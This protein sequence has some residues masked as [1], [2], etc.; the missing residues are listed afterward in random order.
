MKLYMNTMILDTDLNSDCF[1]NHGLHMNSSGKDQ[2]IMKLASVIESI[3]VNNSE[4]NIELQ[5]KDNGINIENM[6]TNQILQPGGVN[7]VLNV[8]VGEI[9]K[10]QLNK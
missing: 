7:Q 3:T 9:C 2:L 4:P 8:E 1:T 6:V 5:W 10:P